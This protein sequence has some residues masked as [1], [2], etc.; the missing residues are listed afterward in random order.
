MKTIGCDK[1]QALYAANTSRTIRT[2]SELGDA[3]PGELGWQTAGCIL[4]YRLSAQARPVFTHHC[5]LKSATDSAGSKVTSKLNFSST[6]QPNTGQSLDTLAR[7]INSPDC[8]LT[9]AHD[10]DPHNKPY[11]T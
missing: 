5:V 10:A 3:K 1:C 7:T 4:V 11:P 8:G 6:K 2:R 9:L